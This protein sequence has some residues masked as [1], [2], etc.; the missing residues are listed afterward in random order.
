MAINLTGDLRFDTR[1]LPEGY[2]PHK[3]YEYR[4]ETLIKNATGLESFLYKYI[5]YSL[6]KSFAI[7]I[8]PTSRFKVS[9]RAITPANRTKWRQTAS[10]LLYRQHTRS[11]DRSTY[12]QTPNFG[13]LSGCWSP[14]IRTTNLNEPSQTGAL[15]AQEPLA[16]YLKDTTSRTR[17]VGSEQGTLELF[18]SFIHSPPRSVGSGSQDQTIYPQTGPIDPLCSAKGGSVNK[19]SGG[20]DFYRDSQYPT[21]S[22]LSKGVHNAL[23]VS[24]ITYAKAL[25]QK[26]AIPMLK[27][28]GPMNRD[29]TL[30]RNVVELKDINRSIVSLQQTLI[31]FKKLFVSLGTQ[32][33]LRRSIF[34]FKNVA[35]DLPN[36]YLSYHFGWKQTFND[37][38]DLLLLP[39]KIS[40][41]YNFLISRSGKPTTF[42]SKKVIDS[43]ESNVSGF[44]YD[45]SDLEYGYPF[46]SSRIERKSEIRLVVN[47]T[48]DFPT[49]NVP[50]FRVKEFLDRIGAVPRA[51]DIYNLIP[52]TWLLDYFTGLGNYIELID[53]INHDE[54]LIN[55]GMISCRTEG[56]LITDFR[57]KSNFT[58]SFYV[59]NQPP[60]TT[61]TTIVENRHTSVLNYECQTRSDVATILDVKL[62]SVPTTLT[63]YQKSI[64]GALLAQRIDFSKSGTF[65]PHS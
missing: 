7:A 38:M 32:P 5:P 37:V 17:L 36:E 65:R 3:L 47:A 59:F 30:F 27:G 26:H 45:I 53:N 58:R 25:C 35:K 22:V 29:Y 19:I 64:I 49:L 14:E 33:S 62:T 40:K 41:K 50:Q 16:D 9:P 44:E 57:S 46:T 61:S 56:K 6:I 52:W 39:N 23:R 8:D 15:R 4:F 12:T 13:N 42:R 60:G 24:E 20:R 51:T 1:G 21:G 10:V 54:S 28:I 2:D 63:A 18:K 31:D 34:D 11:R 48:F 55:W 43:A